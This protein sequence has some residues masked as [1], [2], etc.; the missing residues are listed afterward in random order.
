M[1]VT[2]HITV[3]QTSPTTT[4]AF[5]QLNVLEP[6]HVRIAGSYLGGGGT[7]DAYLFTGV[8]YGSL[9]VNVG[10]EFQF[11]LGPAIPPSSK[12]ADSFIPAGSYLLA[13]DFSGDTD[14]DSTDGFVPTTTLDD[15]GA[16]DAYFRF[17]ISGDVQ[18]V[19]YWE[20]QVIG[21]FK[22]TALPEPTS[23]CAVAIAAGTLLTRRRRGL[24]PQEDRSSRAG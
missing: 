14:W 4:L 12:T 22:V 1:S 21:T 11:I 2:G 18:P 3:S 24:L 6:G 10:P 8:P 17:D 19:A 20:G 13:V 9:S 16:P 7:I 23:S 15:G 5:I